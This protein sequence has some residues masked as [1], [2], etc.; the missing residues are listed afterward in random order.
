M[1]GQTFEQLVRVKYGGIELLVRKQELFVFYATFIANENYKLK[2]KPGDTVLDFGANVGDFTLKAASMLRDKGR[3]IAVEPSHENVA[4]L[5][6]NLELNDVKNVEIYEC[7]IS[8]SD[9]F[10]HLEGKGSVGSHISYSKSEQSDRVKAYSIETFL[11]ESDLVS[12]KDIVVKMDIEGAEKYVLRSHKFIENIREISMELHGRENVESIPKILT[13]EG[14]KVSQYKTSDEIKETIK[15]IVSHPVD[16]L[17]LEKESGY[18]AIKGFL[19]SIYHNNPVP[20]IGNQEL[21]MI[22]ASRKL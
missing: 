9:G 14:F 6:T 15:A 11:A 21:E 19:N 10:V 22:Y 3:L 20:S 16:F 4:I 1:I 18:I 5:K 2:I 8:D 17:K 13:E 7:A 12:Q